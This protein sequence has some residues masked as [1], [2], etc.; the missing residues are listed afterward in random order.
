M[1]NRTGDQLLAVL[2]LVCLFVFK[3]AFEEM[4]VDALEIVDN[5][6]HSPF[7]GSGVFGRQIPAHTPQSVTNMN[8]IVF[9]ESID[10]FF[11]DTENI[12]Y[13]GQWMRSNRERIEGI[14]SREDPVLFFWQ[15]V[16][17]RRS[18]GQSQ[19]LTKR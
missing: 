11:A 3:P 9:K 13:Y 1:T 5:H 8:L 12:S 10:R 4:A 15:S 2:I 7:P 6:C 16:A 17:G 18:E 19:E 14:P